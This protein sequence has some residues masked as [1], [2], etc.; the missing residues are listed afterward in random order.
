MSAPICLAWHAQLRAA[1]Q[2]AGSVQKSDGTSVLPH[3]A[4]PCCM[5]RAC[6]AQTH[7]PYSPAGVLVPKDK[8]IKRFIVSCIGL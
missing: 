8:A 6:Q 7:M 1:P 2:A 3:D 5:M 4:W